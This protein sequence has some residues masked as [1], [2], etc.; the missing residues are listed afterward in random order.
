MSTALFVISDSHGNLPALTAALAWA[1]ARPE[2]SA[3]PT[4][5]GP[6][7]AECEAAVFLGDGAEDLD[8][9]SATAGFSLPWRVVRGNGDMNPSI[10]ESAVLEIAGRRIFLAHGNRHHV[11]RGLQTIS[12]AARAAGAEAVLFG[13]TH[14]PFYGMADGIF[15]CNPGSIGRPRSSLGPSFA[16][17]DIPPSGPPSARFFGL[18]FRGR[19]FAVQPLTL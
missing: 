12:A 17:L 9:A 1:S 16:V 5:S 8:A 15:C 19:D 6:F 2:S 14:V 3:R 11:E 4:L 10:P 18:V 7:P 13:H